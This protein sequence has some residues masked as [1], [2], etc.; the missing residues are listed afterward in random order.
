MTQDYELGED[1]YQEP[2]Q[3]FDF[4]VNEAAL[5]FE[6]GELKIAYGEG[7]IISIG[8]SEQK[9]A[10]TKQVLGQ[11]DFWTAFLGG[12]SNSVDKVAAQNGY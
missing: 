6:D 1:T 5:Y 2:Q 8:M 11:G 4:A 7:Y 12:L 9:Q 10:L 3:E